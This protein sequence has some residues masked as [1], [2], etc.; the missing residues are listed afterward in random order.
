MKPTPFLSILI[1]LAVVLA[2]C[3]PVAAPGNDPALAAVRRACADL[4]DRGR[5]QCIV[6]QAAQALNPEIC[7]LL[8]IYIDDWCLQVVYEAADDPAI[9]DRLYL[10]GIRPTCHAY[11]A[12]PQRCRGCSRPRRC[13]PPST[14][15]RWRTCRTATS[16]CKRLPD[17]A[18][19]RIT[20]D[21]VNS[22][23][24]WSPSGRWLAFRK[25]DSQLWLYSLATGRRPTSWTRAR[26]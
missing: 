24:L 6:D 7:R 4:P 1:L 19:Q 2:A 22:E 20:D 13:P 15:A 10:P 17:G 26:R 23:P 21:G 11:Y 18:P 9:C 12:D 25:L 3:A 5:E 16:G 8:N 14:W